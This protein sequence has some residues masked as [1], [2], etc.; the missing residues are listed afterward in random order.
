MIQWEWSPRWGF[1]LGGLKSCSSVLSCIKPS[2]ASV[3]TQCVLKLSHRMLSAL[4][5][6]CQLNT[7]LPPASQSICEPLKP[8]HLNAIILHPLSSNTI[9]LTRLQCDISLCV[10]VCV[11]VYT[12]LWVWFCDYHR[13]SVVGKSACVCVREREKGEKQRECV[14][15]NMSLQQ[16]V[17]FSDG[18]MSEHISICK[19]PH[20]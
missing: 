17:V 16:M 12:S 10:C 8:L 11:C 19:Y 2:L 1:N 9:I 14:Q 6:W 5:G 13:V 15:R 20:I 18:W 4:G 3:N 7:Y